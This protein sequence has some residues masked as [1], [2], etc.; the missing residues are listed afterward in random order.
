MQHKLDKKYSVGKI[1]ESL[2]K[3]NCYQIQSNYYLFN[4]YDDVL[5]DIGTILDL[6]FSRKYMRLQDIKKNLGNVKKWLFSQELS[7][8][9]YAPNLVDMTRLQVRISI[10][11]LSNSGYII[12]IDK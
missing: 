10:F 5:N 4:Y 12:L 3:C 7:E 2:S 6:D 1:L 9:I 11:L 8:T